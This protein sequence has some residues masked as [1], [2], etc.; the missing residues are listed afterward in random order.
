MVSMLTTKDVQEIINVDRST[1]YRMAESGKLPAVKVGRQWRFPADDLE[2]FLTAATA[3]PAR[4]TEDPPTTDLAT[5]LLPGVAKP[6]ADLLG[7]IF[8]VM[9]LVT[10]LEGDPLIEPSNPCGLFTYVH[11]S[12]QARDRC[13]ATWRDLS[14]DPHL[15]PKFRPTP[16]GFK[17][18]RDLIRVNGETIG[19]VVMG[20]VA[21][22]DWPPAPDEV[23]ALAGDLHVD[24]GGF[25]AHVDEVFRVGED[26]EAWVLDFL[27]RVSALFSRIAKERSLLVER[28]D[29]IASL[30]ATHRR[31][32]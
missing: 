16:L 25:A 30:A 22:P 17:C 15:L 10:D 18:A 29:S 23:E 13:A 20:G 14:S 9:V 3:V 32:I 21:P 31:S 7:S 28:L 12:P 24:P 6:L 11:N 26:H 19:M 27:P 4:E 1:I 8:G 2:A 5:Q